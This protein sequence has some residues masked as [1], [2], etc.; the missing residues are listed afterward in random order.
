[1][2]AQVAPPSR[3]RP[4]VGQDVDRIVAR[5]LARRAEDRYADCGEV[6]E[7][8]APILHERHADARGARRVAVTPLANE[9]VPGTELALTTRPAAFACAGPSSPSVASCSRGPGTSSIR[10][11][12]EAG[13]SAVL[14]RAARLVVA[15]SGQRPTRRAERPHRRG[16][17]PLRG[18]ARPLHA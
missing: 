10:T 4:E 9:D 1:R 3:L 7:A 2:D 11:S 6:V 8:L 18:G 15:P 12:N 16:E 5:L 13:A 14:S 17:A